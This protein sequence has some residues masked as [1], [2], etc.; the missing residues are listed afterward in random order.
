MKSMFS[1]RS[2]AP[3]HACRIYISNIEGERFPSNILVQLKVH[4]AN[5]TFIFVHFNLIKTYCDDVVDVRNSCDV[6][7]RNG[8][9]LN[10]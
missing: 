10:R 4:L 5:I 3:S 6:L 7:R 2:F 9:D 8:R 1:K